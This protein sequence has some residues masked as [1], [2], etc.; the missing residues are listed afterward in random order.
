MVSDTM[1]QA[2][3]ALRQIAFGHV[4]LPSGKNRGMYKSEIINLAREVCDQL[5]IAY[6][7]G[8]FEPDR[9]VPGQ[10]VPLDNS[11]SNDGETGHAAL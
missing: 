1:Q 8:A 4:T 3:R 11:G 6:S 5:G 9:A 10:A 7:N 2:E